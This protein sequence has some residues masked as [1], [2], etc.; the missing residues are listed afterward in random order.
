M[1]LCDIT[2]TKADEMCLAMEECF[3]SFL[4]KRRCERAKEH[5]IVKYNDI[6]MLDYLIEQC[7]FS[8]DDLKVSRPLIE[9]SY[10][11]FIEVYLTTREVNTKSV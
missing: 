1:C 10:Q 11:K 3:K 8:E 2:K 7:H 5:E 4:A 9:A 6:D